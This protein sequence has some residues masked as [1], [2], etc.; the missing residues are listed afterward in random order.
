MGSLKANCFDLH[1]VIDPAE[2]EECAQ[3]V[4]IPPGGQAKFD[5]GLVFEYPE[6][7]AMDV[8][9]RSGHGFN[10]RVRLSNS[11]GIIDEDFRGT[12]KVAL[13]N[14]S[15]KP[16]VV[17]DG[18]RI[19]QARLVETHRYTFVEV[20]E[21][22]ET[23]RGTG[24]IGSTGTGALVASQEKQ[25]PAACAEFEISPEMDMGDGRV[26]YETWEQV[27]RDID[28]KYDQAV[29]D[30]LL[31]GQVH[32]QQIKGAL[33]CDEAFA[34][35]MLERMERE[36]VV[37]T[38][39]AQGVHRALVTLQAWNAG[40]PQAQW[41]KRIQARPTTEEQ[42]YASAR[43]AVLKTG[44]ASISS[45]QKALRTRYT[46]AAELLVRMEREG[47]V[48]PE[49]TFGARTVLLSWDDWVLRGAED[50]GKDEPAPAEQGADQ[51]DAQPA[52]QP[53]VLT[54]AE[55]VQLA[56]ES[57]LMSSEEHWGTVY[58]AASAS[59]LEAF[60]Q[61]LIKRALDVATAAVLPPIEGDVLPPVGSRVYILHGR[62][63][64]AHP[65]IVEGY[66]AWGSLNGGKNDNRV[67]VRVRYED[68]EVR[69]SR[70]LSGVYRTEKA[71]LDARAAGA[72]V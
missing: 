7:W 47:L 48:S 28:R 19:C 16:F 29:Q 21:V 1:V 50:F 67:F 63:N 6:G 66:Y 40:I 46:A 70:L 55:V 5:T 11:T 42:L 41:A 58:R 56:I 51:A 61:A 39:N 9:S 35:L 37:G 4:V 69:N 59:Q 22:S 3:P 24:G 60:A 53:V 54:R 44:K 52:A 64:G 26:T 8:H 32:L 23:E 25:E 31:A 38:G 30:A 10:H 57:G 13:E 36:R 34:K 68:S 65:C 20:A 45:L 72:T 49:N 2:G 15:D 18:D 17:N 12:V 62:D 14:A 71:A 33:G 27:E 43:K